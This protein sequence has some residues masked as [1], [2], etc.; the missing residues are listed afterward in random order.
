VSDLSDELL[1]SMEED[2]KFSL[3]ADY[4]HAKQVEAVAADRMSRGK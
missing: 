4:I 3:A 1:S 2:A